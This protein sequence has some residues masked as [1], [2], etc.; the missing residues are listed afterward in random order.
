MAFVNLS[1]IDPTIIVS[2][3][4]YSHENFTGKRVTGYENPVVILTLQ[5]AQALKQVQE[6]V[7]KNGYSIVVY[8][9][10][11]PQRAVNSFSTWA[12][13]ISDQLKKTH[14]Y[15]RVNKENVFDLGYIMTRSGHSRGSTIDLTL[16]PDGQ[17]IHEINEQKRTLLDGFTITYLDDGTLDMGSSFDLFDVVSHYENSLIEDSYKVR[18]V[19][20]KKVM[21]KYG[22]KNCAEE[23]WHFTLLDEPFPADQDSSYFDFT[24]K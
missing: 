21:E 12:Q 14:Y 9:A 16:I 20:L 17:S 23:W 1:E 2:L 4:Y 8:D 5:A 7:K 11:R 24:I 6:D 19:Y 13:D 18:R 3:R 22:F 10:Y 15:P